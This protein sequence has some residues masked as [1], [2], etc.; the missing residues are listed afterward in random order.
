[1]VCPTTAGTAWF[2]H[3]AITGQR[4]S[5][6]RGPQVTR[7]W[8]SS[9]AAQDRT[10]TAPVPC[11]QAGQ[12]SGPSQHPTGSSSRGYVGGKGGEHTPCMKHPRALHSVCLPGTRSS[13]SSLGDHL[14]TIRTASTS[15]ELP[16]HGCS[17]PTRLQAPQRHGAGH[18][19]TQEAAGEGQSSAKRAPQGPMRASAYSPR[20]IKSKT[21]AC[22]AILAS[23]GGVPWEAPPCLSGVSAADSN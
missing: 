23:A 21:C 3:Q 7:P 19:T 17:L 10:H 18:L 1:M 22:G 5:D 4:D 8:S 12:A 6:P 14:S 16:H 9:A 13:P 2:S 20:C 15:C 11:P